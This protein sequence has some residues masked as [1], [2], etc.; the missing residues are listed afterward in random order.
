MSKVVP[1]DDARHSLYPLQVRYMVQ[2][3]VVPRFGAYTDGVKALQ[4]ESW[5][6]CIEVCLR[7]SCCILTCG[8]HGVH[9]SN[10][11]GINIETGGMPT[12]NPF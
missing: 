9:A 5:S 4:V 2:C 12:L 1:E 11:V 7:L 8:K 10:N 6:R 3:P